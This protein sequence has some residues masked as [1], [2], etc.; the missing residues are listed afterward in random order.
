VKTYLLCASLVPLLR[1]ED[2]PKGGA[3]TQALQTIKQFGGGEFRDENAPAQHEGKVR[4][5]DD[6]TGRLERSFPGQT[7]PVGRWAA[8]APDGRLLA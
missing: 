1:D 2:K 8:F 3:Q 6:R 7:H 4:V 5:Y